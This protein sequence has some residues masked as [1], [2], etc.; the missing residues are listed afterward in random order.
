MILPPMHKMSHGIFGEY[1]NGMRPIQI[2]RRGTRAITKKKET[3]KKTSK[4]NYLML[5]EENVK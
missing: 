3:G 1:R 4:I 2:G 5:D